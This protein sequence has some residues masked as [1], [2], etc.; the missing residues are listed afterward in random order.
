MDDLEKVRE[1]LQRN[2]DLKWGFVIYRCT[3]DN[4]EDWA[5]F[6][7]HLNTRVRL[8]L[9]EDNAG[10]L[11]E[12]IDWAVQEDRDSLDGAGPSRVR[13]RFA[14]W[15]QECEEGD[16][17]LGTPR[18]MACAM[19]SNLDLKTV[20]NGPPAEEFDANGAGFIRLVSL[21]EEEDQL[22]GLSY[23]VPRIYALLGGPG[24]ENIIVDGVAIP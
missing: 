6:M 13:K 20:L 19:V 9:E 11:F 18:F 17:F 1:V 2:A 10:E 21:E 15:L 22:V 12:R 23:V 7:E 3:Y 16:D 8:N 4:D 5:R 24:W 14:E